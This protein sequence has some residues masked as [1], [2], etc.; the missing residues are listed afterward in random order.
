MVVRKLSRRCSF[1]LWYSTVVAKIY[2]QPVSWAMGQIAP[3]RNLSGRPETKS[4]VIV[5]TFCGT[6]AHFLY[7]RV[8]NIFSL[9]I[10][11]K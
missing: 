10:L 6:I 2:F 3:K 8:R 9:L 1:E 4:I 5:H 11:N 7:W